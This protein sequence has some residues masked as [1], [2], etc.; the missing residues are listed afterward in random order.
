[1][2]GEHRVPVT[3]TQ[4]E[5][6]LRYYKISVVPKDWD[7][8]NWYLWIDAIRINQVDIP[9]KN[10]QARLMGDIFRS[11]IVIFTWLGLD[12]DDSHFAVQKIHHLHSL[13]SLVPPDRHVM[14][15]IDET[16]PH[17]W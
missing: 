6:L 13:A 9:E 11:V 3:T 17:L 7:F 10:A 8:A 16:Q 1:M 14:S 2:V 12:E 15:C 5:F 4:E